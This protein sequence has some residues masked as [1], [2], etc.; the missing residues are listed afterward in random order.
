MFGR[1]RS[2]FSTICILCLLLLVS[3]QALRAQTV[4]LTA[5]GE[6]MLFADEPAVD[7][8]FD[9]IF[10]FDSA[11]LPS[12]ALSTSGALNLQSIEGRIGDL[13]FTAQNLSFDG[14]SLCLLYT[15][16]SPRDQRGSRMPSSA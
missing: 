15:S 8:A 16:P 4:Q 13:S 10:T 1:F 12:E 3:L 2:K 7:E 5:E 9:F 6:L 11:I 14:A